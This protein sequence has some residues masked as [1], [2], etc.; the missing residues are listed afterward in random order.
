MTVSR[1]YQL[2]HS[3]RF[4]EA[5]DAYRQQLRDDPENK[6]ANTD[7]LGSSLMAA[8]EYAKAIPFLE[9]VDKYERNSNP[10]SPG[11]GEQLSV[12]HWM[13][14]ERSRALA[15]IKEGVIAVR[16]GTITFTDFAGG[17]SQGVILCYMAA[18]LNSKSDV[19]LALAYLRKLAKR[20]YITGWPGP[21]TLYLLGRVTFLDAM[22]DATGASDLAQ[23]KNVAE[24]HIR[25]RRKLTNLLF[26]AAVERRLAG[27]EPGCGE[28]MAECASLTTQLVEFEWHLAK[29]EAAAQSNG[30]PRGS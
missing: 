14:G 29:A 12:C 23:A 4:R 21:A 22:R 11:R 9:E 3:Y 24:Q 27:D 18:T 2:F 26:A 20:S 8:E 25:S 13:M 28:Y 10:G 6:W 1:A 16:D 30:A 17:T 7:G 15:L 19:D 5:V